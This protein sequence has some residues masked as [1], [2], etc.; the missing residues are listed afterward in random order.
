[1]SLMDAFP[2]TKIWSKFL[3]TLMALSTVTIFIVGTICGRVILVSCCHRVAPS[4]YADSYSDSSRLTMAARNSAAKY[5]APFQ[6][7]VKIMIALAKAG[8]DINTM[9]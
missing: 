4:I 7:P 1:M 2:I 9:G 8:S 3:R 6:A 5:P